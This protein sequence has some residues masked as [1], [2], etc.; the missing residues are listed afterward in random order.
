MKVRSYRN[1]GDEFKRVGKISSRSRNSGI[2]T[3]VSRKRA[4]GRAVHITLCSDRGVGGYLQHCCSLPQ[5]SAF[6]KRVWLHISGHVNILLVAI[7]N[8]FSD[9]VIVVIF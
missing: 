2:Y 5:K 1:K 6:L 9:V 3:V 8:N 7:D 4:Y